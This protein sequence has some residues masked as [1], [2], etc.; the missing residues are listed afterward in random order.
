HLA[1]DRPQGPT[2]TG[3]QVI[4]CRHKCGMTLAT[5]GVPWISRAL[6]QAWTCLGLGELGANLIDQLA[7]HDAPPSARRSAKPSGASAAAS[8][9]SSIYRALHD[10]RSM[11]L[12]Q[13]RKCRRSLGRWMT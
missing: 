8:D 13:R 4:D 10:V 12:R 3:E 1:G 6:G 5:K 9:S 7:A 11:A 2:R